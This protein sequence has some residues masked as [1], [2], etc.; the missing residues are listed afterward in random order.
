MKYKIAGVLVVAVMLTV[1]GRL[2][3][4]RNIHPAGYIS[5][6]LLEDRKRAV[7]VMAGNYARICLWC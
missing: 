6:R 5:M 7:T 1:P 2:N 3:R 4:N